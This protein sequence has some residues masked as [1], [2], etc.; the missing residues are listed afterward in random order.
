[1]STI[2]N[3]EI[4]KIGT[5][6][7]DTY[8]TADL[9]EMVAAHK[10]LDF[11]PA[12]KIGH[13]KDKPGAP[14]YGWVT[15]LKRIGEK[16][17]ADFESMHDSVINAIRSKMYDRV[18]SEIYFNLKR[19][20]K[21]FRRALKAVALLGA[22]VPAVANLVPLHKME[23]VADGFA[24]VLAYTQSFAFT[25]DAGDEVHRLVAEYRAEHPQVKTY[26]DALIAVRQS[27]PS[28]YRE[29]AQISKTPE[30]ADAQRMR[31]ALGLP[32]PKERQSAGWQIQKLVDELKEAHPD[33]TQMQCL[34]KVLSE[35]P[36][37]AAAY[38]GGDRPFIPS[39]DAI[40][41]SGGPGR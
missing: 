31:N 9:D 13:S 34:K 4:F 23:F 37:L 18:S 20:G 32:D 11:R 38:Q 29:Y 21:T 22:E 14:A 40:M 28:L 1:M 16:L 17:Y 36:E 8:T 24:D 26:E 30:E 27:H 10:A 12:L 33:W 5:H 25:E 35:N 41:G 6:N 2:R 15:N 19:G 39:F 7:S 3:V